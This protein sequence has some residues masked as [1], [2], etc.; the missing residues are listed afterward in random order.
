[1]NSEEGA[2][3][4]QWPIIGIGRQ[5][6]VDTISAGDQNAQCIIQIFSLKIAV[7]CIG[8]EH[9]FSRPRIFFPC[10]VTPI[11]AVA[12]NVL[13]PL[14]QGALG[15]KTSN[16][17]QSFTQERAASRHIEEVMPLRSIRR[18]VRQKTD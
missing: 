6:S 13:A 8:E 9:H 15:G 18:I 7:E 2:A 11:G 12:I 4:A 10:C 1:T 16:D 17:L 3:A 14:W 5:R